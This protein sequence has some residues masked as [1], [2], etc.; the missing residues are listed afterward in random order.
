VSCSSLFGSVYSATTESIYCTSGCSALTFQ[1][2]D[3]VFC[4]FQYNGPVSLNPSST[5]AVRIFI[6]NP[7]SS[8]C[9]GI[10]GNHT[11]TQPTGFQPTY[12]NFVATHGVGNLLGSTHPSQ[13]QVYVAGNGS[14]N[15]TVAYS[16]GDTTLSAQD[17]FLYA[18]TSNVT[19]SAGQRCSTL[20]GQTLCTTA[21]TL[22]G[23]FIGW[24][25]TVGG[26]AIA[27]DLGLLNYPLSNTLGPFHVKQY[28]ECTPA[29]PLPSPATSG[30]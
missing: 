26:T 25:L 22:A 28:V 9:S 7:H 24:D 30:C 27:Q 23:A 29:Y 16:T 11:G 14:N 15:G 8:R 19:V 18:P 4:D 5:Q 1:P 6:D 21:G 12:G 13:G 10:S 2:G 20:L 17:M 3:Y